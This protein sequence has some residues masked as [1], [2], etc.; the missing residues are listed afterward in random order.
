MRRFLLSNIVGVVLF[1]A[2]VMML[3]GCAKDKNNVPAYI[4]IDA[5]DL[6]TVETP[7]YGMST[8]NISDAWVWVDDKL[9]GAFEL[10]AT[11]PV[12]HNGGDALIEIQPGIK[13]NGIA[14]SRAEYP[15]YQI[16][17][18]TKRLQKDSVTNITNVSTRYREGY[19]QVAWLENFDGVGISLDTIKPGNV[20]I[21][22]SGDENEV[23]KWKNEA[24][25]ACGKVVMQ[26]V[27]SKFLGISI[28]KFAIPKNGAYAFL[29]LDIKSTTYTEVGLIDAVTNRTYP[30]MILNVADEWKHVYVNVTILASTLID[31]KEFKFYFRANGSDDPQD[32]VYLDNIKLIYR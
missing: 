13:I 10:P 8:H 5:I 23:L 6:S 12:L 18:T 16:F 4:H 32:V 21:G 1:V 27:E 25:N 19:G 2:V 9:I 14:S 3:N 15:F 31:T 29:E 11:F 7:E 24:N 17:K 28:D 26:G 30:L 20:K 22:V